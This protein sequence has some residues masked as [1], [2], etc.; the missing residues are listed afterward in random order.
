MSYEDSV[1]DHYLH[2]QLLQSIKAALPKL[3]KTEETI[4]T[5]DLAVMDEFHIGGRQA[6]NHVVTKLNIYAGSHVLDIG[7]GLGGAARYV[8]TERK[9]RVTGIDLS[10]EYIK[11]GNALCRWLNLQQEVSLIQGS[12]LAMPF[13]DEVFSSA[14]MLHV[15]MNIADK[16]QLFE[17]VYRVLKP[18][19]FF[20]IYDVMRTSEGDIRYPVPWACDARTSQLKTAKEYTQILSDVGFGVSKANDR[21]DFALAFFDKLQRN[22]ATNKEPPALGLHTLMQESTAEKVKNMIKNIEGGQLAPV[23]IIAYRL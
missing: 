23:E 1:A 7:C 20:G 8:A 5:Q 2:G 18:R 4:T 12:A 13:E 14:Y 19:T 22:I 3:G 10:A 11:T 21:R 16:K 9:C 6:T 15:G 17:E